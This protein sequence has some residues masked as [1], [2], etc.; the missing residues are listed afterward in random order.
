LR[1]WLAIDRS[2]STA[3]FLKNEQD[4]HLFE[5]LAFCYLVS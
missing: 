4:A 3:R 2:R 5:R 1:G